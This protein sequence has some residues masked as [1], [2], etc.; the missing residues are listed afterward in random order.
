MDGKLKCK[1]C[2]HEWW[3]RTVEPVEC[4]RCQNKFWACGKPGIKYRF[5]TIGIGETKIYNMYWDDILNVPDEEKNLNMYSALRSYERRHP[6]TRFA[7]LHVGFKM[8]V[9]RKA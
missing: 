8:H 1:C 4:P 5:D 9:Y 6:G 2:E 7:T 3:K